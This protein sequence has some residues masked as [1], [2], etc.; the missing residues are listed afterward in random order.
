VHGLVS[1][2]CTGEVFVHSFVAAKH[3]GT[4]LP[5]VVHWSLWTRQYTMLWLKWCLSWLQNCS[6]MCH[7]E[8]GLALWSSSRYC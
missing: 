3:Y 1:T 2:V 6:I 7:R 5:L 4:I 8:H